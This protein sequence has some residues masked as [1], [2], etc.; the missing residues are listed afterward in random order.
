M[1]RRLVSSFLSLA[2]ILASLALDAQRAAAQTLTGRTAPVVATPQLGA[3]LGSVVPTLTLTAPALTLSAPLLSAPAVLSAAPALQIPVAPALAKPALAAASVSHKVEA[4][5]PALQTLAQPK[6]GVSAAATAGRDLETVLTGEIPAA[7]KGDAV[8][9]AESSVPSALAPVSAS[10][11]APEAPKTDAVPAAKPAEPKT[12]RTATSYSLR[13]AVLKTVAAVTGAVF[14][15]PQAGPALTAKIIASASDKQLVLSDF[16]DTLAGYNEVLPADKVAAVGAIRAAGK[17]FAV[18][19]DRGD[20]KRPNST[21]LTVFES[22]ESLPVATREGMYVAANSGGKVYRYDADG[23]PQLVHEAAGL[24]PEQVEQVKAAAAATKARLSEVGATQHE[25]DGKNPAESFNTYGYAI[26]LK[27]GSSQEAV[28]GV[29][30]ILNEELAK[31][32]FDVEVQPRFAKSAENPPY[33]TFSIITKAD[34]AKYIAGALKV[35]TKDALIVGDAMFIPRDAKKASWLT[36]LGERL[37]GRPQAK[38]GN[39]T[40]RNME[41]GLPGVLALGVGTQMDPRVPNGYA[42]AGHGPAVTQ[43]VLEAVASKPAAPDSGSKTDGSRMEAAMQLG[44]IGLVVAAAAVGYFVIA[45]AI[46]DIFAMGERAIREWHNSPEGRDGLFFLGATTLGM[47]GMMTPGSSK[48]LAEPLAAFTVALKAATDSAVSR[49]AKAEDV[50]FV[51]ATASVGVDGWKFTFLA[52]NGKGGTDLL[53]AEGDGRVR[54][55]EGAAAPANTVPFA[56][57]AYLMKKGTE[58]SPNRALDLLREKLPGFASGYSVSLAVQEEPESGDKD[59]WYRF[60]DDKGN[61]GSV[62]G[63]TGEARVDKTVAKA[64][65]GMKHAVEP[66]ELFALALDNAR[67][68]AKEM[69]VAPERVRFLSGVHETRYFNGAWVGDEWR[70]HFAWGGPN[71]GVQY[72]VPARRTM[73]TETMM[74]AFEPKFVGPVS[75]K[76][77]AAGI[78]A[79][80]FGL[81]VKVTPE[82]ALKSVDGV[83]RVSLLARTQSN[84][85]KDLWYSLQDG[86]GEIAAVNA[87]TGAVVRPA[88]SAPTSSLKSFLLWALGAGLVALV[89]GGLYW[90]MTH[91]PAA[92]PQGVPE[93]YNGPIPTIDQVFRGMGGFLGMAGML[94]MVGYQVPDFLR[95]PVDDYAAAFKAAAESV[96]GL[97]VSA[98]DLRFAG[99]TANTRVSDGRHWSY[100]FTY[101]VKEGKTG[102]LYVDMSRQF[103]GSE[104]EARVTRYS[105]VPTIGETLRGD[106]VGRAVALDAGASLGLVRK[107]HP[108]FGAQA[109]VSL[110]LLKDSVT[111]DADL[112]YSFYDDDGG[113]AQVNARTG[114]VKLLKAPEPGVR[115]AENRSVLLYV[116]VVLAAL[117]AAAFIAHGGLFAGG[118]IGAGMFGV[119]KSGKTPKPKVTDD[120]VKAAVASV[121]SSKG[122]VWSQTE[123]NMGYSNVYESLK[124]RGATKRQLELFKKLCDE[125]PVIGGRFNPWSGD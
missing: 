45:H 113:H 125:A 41:K 30:A 44:L 52:P 120:Q 71:G 9:G 66:N 100:S 110:T 7:A 32:G 61:A 73:I 17:H 18:I 56:M 68:K 12:V 24:T 93:G 42:L 101:P 81:A 57:S 107:D 2:L 108:S 64:P 31:R 119:L 4:I 14:T 97:G 63:R 106:L 118:V 65:E 33:A 124:S 38:T 29:A 67:A 115:K 35:E 19:S 72:M 89:Y 94:G 51:E 95:S 1:A 6:S 16:D 114:Q 76:D 116:A 85:D 80:L 8:A 43:K 26:M 20:V 103:L 69:N 104:M 82:T 91:A 22:L 40:D 86:S 88:A 50:R 15:L 121:V 60:Y 11:S 112:W 99:A 47:V 21:Q 87:R 109:S 96:K 70:F 23:V 58:V 46:A 77:L 74:D 49:G 10:A 117:A 54:V 102:L 75:A 36:K 5:A 55:Y 34:A 105:S 83:K 48:L 13:R 123:Y 79:G 37:S 84:G 122:G 78:D 111:G 25:A 3:G 27:P 98:A 90:A 62:N 53:Y 28:K 92:V 39:E 59:A